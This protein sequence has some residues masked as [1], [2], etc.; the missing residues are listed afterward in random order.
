LPSAKK[1]AVYFLPNPKSVS[2]RVKPFSIGDHGVE[3]GLY[4]HGGCF[5]PNNMAPG[6]VIGRYCSI[7]VTACAFTRNHPM[8]LRSSHALFF[9]PQF[10]FSQIDYVPRQRLVIGHDVWIGHNAIILPSVS[11]VGDGAV[12]SAG[13]LVNKN[14]PPYAV[15]T[16]NP[17][18]VVRYRFS[19]S[20]IADLQASRWWELSLEEL[21]ARFGE[22]QH[23]LEG[24]SVR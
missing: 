24:E 7:A 9:N 20:V 17:S 2:D 16:G 15:V 19:D 1:S 3:V 10:G 23:P 6:V 18:R 11:S 4:T 13:S 21:L 12:I 22:F 5:V 14:V 8:N